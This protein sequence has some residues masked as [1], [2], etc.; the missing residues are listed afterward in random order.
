MHSTRYGRQRLHLGA[1]S[2]LRACAARRARRRKASETP[3]DSWLGLWLH[4]CGRTCT[5]SIDATSCAAHSI[6]ASDRERGALRLS[7]PVAKRVILRRMADAAVLESESWQQPEVF[8]GFPHPSTNRA[9]R[10]VCWPSIPRATLEAAA[11]PAARESGCDRR[12]H[13]DT[14]VGAAKLLSSV[15]KGVFA[16]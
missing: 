12:W 10:A 16:K 8:P 11:P 9:Q 7:L 3:A 14:A 6:A 1:R 4:V 2:W 13:T 15:L 5:A